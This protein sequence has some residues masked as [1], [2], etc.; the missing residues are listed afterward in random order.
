ML[1]LSFLFAVAEWAVCDV[2]SREEKAAMVV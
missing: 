1:D 2:G